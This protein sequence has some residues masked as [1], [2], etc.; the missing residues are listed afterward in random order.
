MARNVG[1][2]GGT[3]NPIHFGHLRLAEE[4]AEKLSLNE[5]RLIPSA[6]P[7]HKTA[8][9]V[10][11]QHRANMVKLATQHHP[12]LVLDDCELQ[13]EGASYTVDTLIELRKKLG[14]SVSLFL[15][16]GSDAFAHLDTWH[17]WQEILHYC[18]IA[19]VQR[20]EHENTLENFSSTMK[21]FYQAHCKENLQ[22]LQDSPSGF[23]TTQTITPLAISSTDIRERLKNNQSVHS[24]L[25]Q[26]VLQYIQENNLYR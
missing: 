22:D 17:R 10:S 26:Q 16:M 1:I 15:I 20:P 24:L 5:V 3:F 25:P 23:I 13:R 7:P 8:P 11:A 2:L 9:Q 6:N 14:E 19:L 4:I 21:S 12:K 18:H